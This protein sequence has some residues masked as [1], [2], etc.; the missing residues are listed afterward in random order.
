M[1][2]FCGGVMTCF[3]LCP[4]ASLVES[5]AFP[6]IGSREGIDTGVP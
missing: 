5:P 6:F 4:C 1:L 3:A 2:I